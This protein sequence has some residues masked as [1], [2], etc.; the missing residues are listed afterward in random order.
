MKQIISNLDYR[1]YFK[2]LYVP[3]ESG[4]RFFK[5][6]NGKFYFSI[7]ALT[8]I[9]V[10]VFVYSQI[11][12]FHSYFWYLIPIYFLICNYI[13]YTLHRY[14]IHK[15]TKGFEFLFEHVTVHH[16]Y[17]NEKTPYI[18]EPKDVMAVFLPILYFIF[19]SLEFM[20]ISAIIYF[21]I[22]Y[23]NAVFF[24]FFAYRYYLMYEILH[25]SYHTPENSFIKKIPFMK[26]LAQFHLNHH[27]SKL[28][29]NYNFN[30]TFPI[31]DKI[32]NTAYKENENTLNREKND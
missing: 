16:R 11:Q 6:T 15:K 10:P 23:N 9:S 27:E 7:I 20:L 25:F 30:I 8:L 2:T 28:I 14:P 5:I 24:A 13:E 26:K 22:D 1:K 17:Y 4:F 21:F 31:F 32:F 29:N 12:I 3:N 19:I 18:E